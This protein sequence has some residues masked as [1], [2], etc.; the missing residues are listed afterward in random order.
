MVTNKT[1]VCHNISEPHSFNE[2]IFSIKNFTGHACPVSDNIFA[3]Q[4][5]K[6]TYQYDW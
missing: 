1:V 5:E 6:F 2:T 4:T 3:G